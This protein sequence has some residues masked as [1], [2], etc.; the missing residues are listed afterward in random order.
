MCST[1]GTYA[2]PRIF[3]LTSLDDQQL[4]G[5]IMWVPGAL[6]FWIAI[7]IIFFRWAGRENREEA[8]HRV[9]LGGSA[10]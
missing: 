8:G 9:M 5:L 3:S 6:V 10:T 1:P 2:A 4:G 7:S